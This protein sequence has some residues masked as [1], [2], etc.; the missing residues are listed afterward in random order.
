MAAPASILPTPRGPSAFWLLDAEG[1][2][3]ERGVRFHAALDWF[4][5]AGAIVRAPLAGRIV[6]VT[7][8][9]GRVGQVFGGVVKL[10]ADDGLIYVMRHVDPGP[11][12]EGQ[13]MRAGTAL[14]R[15][16]DWQGGADHVHLEVWREATYRGGSGYRVE[17]MIDPGTLAWGPY[18]AAPVPDQLPIPPHGNTLRLV[19]GAREWAGWPGCAGPLK[20]VAAHGIAGDQQRAALAW[21]GEVW[22]G[23]QDVT[24]VA[25]NLVRRFLDPI[26]EEDER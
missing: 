20:W 12:T 16:T 22:R 13:R 9:R 3:N 14:A 19:I 21:R 4:A 2:K 23:P 11:I 17:N 8:S 25:R 5:P 1:A 10:H 15:V 18:L 7:P 6:E 26:D 24:N